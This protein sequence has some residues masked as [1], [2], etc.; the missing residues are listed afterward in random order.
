MFVDS[1][2]VLCKNWFKKVSRYIREDVGAIWGVDIPREIKNG[3]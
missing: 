1:D 2:V 3:F